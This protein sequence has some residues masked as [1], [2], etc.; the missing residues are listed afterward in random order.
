MKKIQLNSEIKKDEVILI[1]F[2]KK[3]EY[4]NNDGLNL[5]NLIS[6]KGEG[7]EDRN[8]GFAK[9]ATLN[10]IYCRGEEGNGFEELERLKKENHDLNDGCD[11]IL[12]TCWPSL[13]LSNLP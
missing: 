9:I 2:E 5:S 6:L 10:V 11:I 8:I 7:G 3:P 1:T 4:I 13:I 12:S